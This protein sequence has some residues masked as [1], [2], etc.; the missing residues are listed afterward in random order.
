MKNNKI[1]VMMLQFK[2]NLNSHFD[3]FITILYKDI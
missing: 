2:Y 3:L 1:R